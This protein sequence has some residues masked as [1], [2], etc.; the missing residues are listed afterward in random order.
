MAKGVVPDI[1][2]VEEVLR[3]F[4]E[5]PSFHDA[6]VVCF[7]LHRSRP[8]VMRVHTFLSPNEK[9]AVVSFIMGEVVGMNMNGF[10]HQNVIFDLHIEKRPSG[11]YEITLD[12]CYGLAGHIATKGLRF[13]VVPGIPENSVYNRKP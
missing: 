3:Y 7:E 10:N 4:G 13:E 8:S 1:P 9:H 5:W 11:E 6:E 2:G 12:P